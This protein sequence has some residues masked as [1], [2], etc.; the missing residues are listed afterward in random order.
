MMHD[1]MIGGRSEERR[2]YNHNKWMVCFYTTPS[3]LCFLNQPFIQFILGP[4]L[5]QLLLVKCLF[6]PWISVGGLL[7]VGI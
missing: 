6:S 3:R 1:F 5:K 2:H 4:L 7:S